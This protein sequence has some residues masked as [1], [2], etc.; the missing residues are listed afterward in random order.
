L[1]SF[2]TR[3]LSS[4]SLHTQV[5]VN[6]PLEND[7]ERLSNLLWTGSLSLL[8]LLSLLSRGWENLGVWDS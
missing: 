7:L 1:A 2:A 4:P 3:R 5:V 6:T 8:S